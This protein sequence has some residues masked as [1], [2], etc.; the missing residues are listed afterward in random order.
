MGQAQ[1]V[2]FLPLSQPVL[3]GATA[4]FSPMRTCPDRGCQIATLLADQR[5]AVTVDRFGHSE[6]SLIRGRTACGTPLDRAI[7]C[8]Q[9]SRL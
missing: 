2:I 6:S 3:A 7:W 5:V 4:H 8:I 9:K 1:T